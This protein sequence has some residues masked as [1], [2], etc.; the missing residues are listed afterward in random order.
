[1]FADL[2]YVRSLEKEVDELQ[3]DKSEFSKEYD[4][5]LQEC[6]SKD[7]MCSILHSVADIDEQIE[8]QCLYLEK[9]KECES[10]KI[11]P[12]KQTKNVSK[13]VYNELLRSFAKLENNPFLLNLLYNNLPQ[14]FRNTNPR[15]ST[16]TRVIHKTSVSRPQLRSTKMKDKVVQN[17]SQVKIKKTE[18]EDHHRISSFSNKTESV[19]TCNGILMS[20]TSNANA[21]CAT[22]GKCVFNSNHDSCVSKF[23][24]DVNARTKKPKLVP[25]SA[26]KPKKHANQSI[27]TPLRKQLLHSPL[28]RNPGFTLGCFM[29]IQGMDL[30]DRK[31]VSIRIKWIPKLKKKWVPKIRNDIVSTSIS[32]TI[33][34]ESRISND[35]SPINDLGFNVS[36]VPP[37][38]NSLAYCSN[39]P[40]HFSLQETSSPT[41]ICFMSKTS[42]TQTWL[43][44]QRLSHLNFDTINLLSKKDIMNGLPKLKYFKDQLC[45]SCELGKAKR[46]SFKI[47]T[48]A[49]SKGLINL[50]YMDLC[51]PMW[52]KSINGK[53]YILVIIDEYS[54][55]TWTHF[56]R[57]KDETPEVFKD[58]LK[59]IQQN[60]QAQVIIVRTD[61]GI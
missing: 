35:S 23:I 41:P 31:T 28:S 51:G 33:D 7:I 40:I 61:R 37:S 11:K 38:S 57:S 19:T 42:L 47:K 2:K 44:H 34:I 52:I 10:L 20:R 56:L 21:V 50:L 16:S 17:Y 60:L 36:N 55:Y 1:M 9:I 13:E 5:L 26:R 22:C 53:K 59:M 12:S 58:F 54:Q 8:M 43:W 48:I 29:R 46:S 27:S 3:T 15:V 30:V 45:S 32:P 4:L 49:S 6:V 25:I 24:N 39:N 18:V 14:T